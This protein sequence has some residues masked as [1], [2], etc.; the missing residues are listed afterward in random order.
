MNQLNSFTPFTNMDGN[1]FVFGHPSEIQD[2]L[3][4]NHN[5]NRLV[6]TTPYSSLPNTTPRLVFPRRPL[7][8]YNIFFQLER[9][10][11]INEEP[12]REFTLDDALKLLEE[13]RIIRSQPQRKRIHRKCHGKIGFK[14]M[15]RS[16]ADAWKG[17][18]LPN[19]QI[20]EDCAAMERK[21]YVQEKKEIKR[22][23]EEA[24]KMAASVIEEPNVARISEE[25]EEEGDCFNQISPQENCEDDCESGDVDDP[26]TAFENTEREV[27]QQMMIVAINISSAPLAQ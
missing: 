18:S 21:K 19:R 6:P 25:I 9:K 17:L 3:H 23:V 2:S 8:A 10:R 15:A 13:Q 14:E 7:S 1:P 5:D 16:I 11:M 27:F 20:F 22:L 12:K 26:Y 24:A 4:C